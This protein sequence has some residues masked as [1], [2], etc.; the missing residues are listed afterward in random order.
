MSA[1][2]PL[3]EVRN[4]T[5]SV[6][7]FDP[8]K[9]KIVGTRVLSENS[10]LRISS[11]HL[12]TSNEIYEVN[13]NVSLTDYSNDY[14]ILTDKI[15]YY[16]SKDIIK[17]FNTTN[18]EYKNDFFIQT[19]NISFDRKTKKFNTNNGHYYFPTKCKYWI[20]T[21]ENEPSLV[22]NEKNEK[23]G[24]VAVCYECYKKT[25]NKLKCRIK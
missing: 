23:D 15:I 25:L 2:I 8:N 3:E 24:L 20:I 14:I 10:D 12:N 1:T 21:R 6:Y 5:I 11:T 17:S 4:L 16:K 13:K 18:I 22:I 19:K 7:R 9:D